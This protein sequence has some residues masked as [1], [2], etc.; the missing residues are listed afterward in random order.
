[1]RTDEAQTPVMDEAAFAALIEAY[2]AD[3][4]RWPQDRRAAALALAQTPSVARRLDSAARLDAALAML[5]APQPKAA[6]SGR[7][8]AD[9]ER[10][11]TIRTRLRRWLVGA[12]LI[13]I[14]LAG[15]LTGAMAVAV[16]L[17]GQGAGLEI[18]SGDT[19]FGAIDSDLIRETP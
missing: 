5:A 6:L 11:V 18:A 1:M 4:M 10:H 9:A 15:G 12:G 7:I 2:G 16:V 19:A 17:P 13:G 3:P 8:L 14:G